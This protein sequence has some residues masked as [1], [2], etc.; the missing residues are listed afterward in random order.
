MKILFFTIGNNIVASSRSRVYGYLPYLK[1]EG[2]KYK[3]ITFTSGPKC[4]RI[5]AVEKDN[6]FGRIS[7]FFYKIF[8]MGKFLVLSGQYDTIFVQKV[9]LPRIIWDMATR[10][11]KRVIFDFDDAIYLY[12]DIGYIL[13][14]AAC[15]T[16]SNKYL[17]EFASRH[18]SSVHELISPVTSCN[19]SSKRE[20][21]F[22]TLGWIGSP[23]TTRYLYPLLPVFKELKGKHKNLNIEFMGAEKNSNFN[24]EHITIKDWSIKE[25]DNWLGN[26]DI[27]IMPLE[28]DKWSESKGGYKL[29]LYMSRGAACVASPVGIN[30]EIIK[31]NVNGYLARSADDWRD[32][33]SRLIEDCDLRLRF[34]SEA[35]NLVERLYSYKACAPKLIGV[36]NGIYPEIPQ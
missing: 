9:T 14:K 7:E 17:R 29:L 5:L 18:N 35:R 4:R 10:I 22:V 11:N 1:R 31:D 3:I 13:K 15:V 28:H 30:T 8:T 32:R 12:R 24:T 33:L 20:G 19:V 25:E 2:I 27:G 34:G 21:D 26:I 16:V 6:V 23:E 36:L